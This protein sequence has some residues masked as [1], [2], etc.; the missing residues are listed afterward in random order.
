M[1]T[2]CTLS[3]QK[4]LLTTVVFH[5]F[6]QSVLVACHGVFFTQLIVLASCATLKKKSQKGKIDMY[7][8]LTALQQQKLL[9]KKLGF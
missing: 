8:K 9:K 4:L 5:H 6:V 2:L 7:C 3:S 1:L